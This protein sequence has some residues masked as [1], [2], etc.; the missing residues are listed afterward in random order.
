MQDAIDHREDVGP[1]G[2]QDIAVT[3]LD[4]EMFVRAEPCIPTFSA[5]DRIGMSPKD[6]KMKLTVP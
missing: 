6:W 1:V 5:A 3:A 2:F 4:E